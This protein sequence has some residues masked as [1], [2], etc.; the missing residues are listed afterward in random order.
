MAQLL[1]HY[2]V[3]HLLKI[4]ERIWFPC[5]LVV[6]CFCYFVKILRNSHPLFFR[7]RFINGESCQAHKANCM[8]SKLK[9]LI[10]ISPSSS[11][12]DKN[13]D[14]W[15]EILMNLQKILTDKFQTITDT[16]STLNPDFLKVLFNCHL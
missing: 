5:A 15:N 14:G 7:G 12:V 1:S 9:F 2:D 16:S 13:C 11:V 3:I 10:R 8:F 4:G 6:V